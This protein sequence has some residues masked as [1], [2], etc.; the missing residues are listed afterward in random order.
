MIP[1]WTNI[2]EG[3]SIGAVAVTIVIVSDGLKSIGIQTEVALLLAGIAPGT[4]LGE[5]LQ[6]CL[7]VLEILR[8]EAFGEPFVN[9]LEEVS[10]FRSFALALP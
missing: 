5:F 7:C 8:L 1:T 6:Q 4:A 2:C 10:G 3:Q 9:G